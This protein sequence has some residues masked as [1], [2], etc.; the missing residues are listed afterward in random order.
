MNC[1]SH[2]RDS[3]RD[4]QAKLDPN[5]S[6]WQNGS[7]LHRQT[8]SKSGNI[9]E[10]HHA[11]RCPMVPQPNG[12]QHFQDVVK[13]CGVLLDTTLN[14][15]LWSIFQNMACGFVNC[16]LLYLTKLESNSEMRCILV[17]CLFSKLQ[18]VNCWS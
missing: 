1:P 18:Y 9:G 2:L 10:L 14:Q 17:F 15:T 8:H 5:R 13:V 11:T 12:T 6:K 4:K 3:T 7:G 16:L